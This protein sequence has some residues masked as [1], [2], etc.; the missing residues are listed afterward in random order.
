VPQLLVRNVDEFVVKKLRRRAV[1][2]GVSA[3][4]EHRRILREALLLPDERQ[5][6]L[7]EFL[8]TDQGVASEVELEIDRS[9]S[10]DSHRDL[11][12]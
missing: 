11:T 5:Q 1:L 6:S 4:E 12:W 8:L 2:H 7:M 10:T 3:E 9:Q